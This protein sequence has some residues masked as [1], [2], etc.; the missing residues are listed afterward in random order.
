MNYAKPAGV[1]AAASG[2]SRAIAWPWCM[3]RGRGR[4]EIGWGWIVASVLTDCA[5][6]DGSQVS[7]LLDRIGGSAASLTADGALLSR[8]SL[9]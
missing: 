4:P 1:I 9:S 6:D 2:T 3:D 7:P 5:A 8:P